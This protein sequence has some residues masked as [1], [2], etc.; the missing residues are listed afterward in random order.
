[1]A[2]FYDF[3]CSPG[4]PV[5]VRGRLAADVRLRLGDA[6]ALE[7]LTQLKMATNVDNKA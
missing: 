2:A 1:V 3:F 7:L 6:G 5:S 4:D